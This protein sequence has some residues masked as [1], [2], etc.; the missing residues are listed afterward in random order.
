MPDVSPITELIAYAED[1]VVSRT[2]LKQKG[3]SATL[4]AFAEGEGLSEHTT[5][6]DALVLVTDG[7]ASITVGSTTFTV[8]TGET[9]LLPANVPH[10]LQ[11]K[12][13]FMMLLIMLR[14]SS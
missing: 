9:I 5:P 6:S 4:F 11:A 10:A 8:G 12:R 1:S 13:P 3:G 7:E 14:A 2:L